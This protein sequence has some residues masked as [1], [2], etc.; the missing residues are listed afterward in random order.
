MQ[1]ESH[2]RARFDRIRALLEPFLDTE[3]RLATE[4]VLAR[5]AGRPTLSLELEHE[6]VSK[7]LD[8]GL[9]YYESAKWDFDRCMEG[10][11]W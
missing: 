3:E 7:W 4:I 10:C 1:S 11:T 5:C 9:A 8:V 6:L 2:Y